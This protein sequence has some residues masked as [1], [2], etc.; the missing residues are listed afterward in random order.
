MN[1]ELAKKINRLADEDQEFRKKLKIGTKGNSKIDQKNT[2]ELKQIIKEYGWP[3]IPLVGKKASHNAWLLAQHADLDHK[4][5]KKVLNMLR[6]IERIQPASVRLSN[7]AYLTDRVLVAENKKQ[8]FGTQFFASKETGW[9]YIPRPIRDK[10]NLD[11]R[12]ARYG[13]D[14]FE[15]YVKIM[16]KKFVKIR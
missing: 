13:L 3:T 15:S 7:I 12:R 16:G 8:E 2:S 5:Q 9:K 14:G 11:V 4:F 10:K 6:K 1:K